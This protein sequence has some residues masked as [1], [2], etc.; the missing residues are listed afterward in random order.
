MTPPLL[1]VPQWVMYNF[2]FFAEHWMGSRLLFRVF[3]NQQK[4]LV[5]SIDKTAGS[6]KT[7][8]DPLSHYLIN[9]DT[10]TLPGNRPVIYRNAAGHWN[11]TR[12]WSF[13]FFSEKYG[14]RQIDLY[15]TAGLTDPRAPT[16]SEQ[17][18]LSSFIGQIRQGSLKYLKL[19]N[20]VNNEKVL[21]EALDLKWLQRFKRKTSFGETFYTFMGGKGTVT[22]LHDEFPCNLYVQIYG[23]KK[24]VIYPPEDR[25]F[26]DART[27]RRPYFFSDVCPD[28]IGDPKH[29]LQQYAN[30]TEIILHPGDVLW[31]PPF[32][33]HYVE[34]ITD[35]IG[36]AYKFADIPAACRSSKM[37]SVL[38]FLSTRPSIFYSFIAN[39]F[40]KEDPILSKKYN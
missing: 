20:L 14:D 13:D 39:R 21:Q 36:V 16:T 37:L 15:Y 3:G 5:A 10:D 1:S 35:S 23:V 11:S 24:W 9:G 26:L 30:K 27:E 38:F 25:V 12:T 8:S 40:S 34:N 6:R 18:S 29:P 4:K 19:S 33:W 2:L 31:V 22:P 28:N 7:S 32:V 17:I